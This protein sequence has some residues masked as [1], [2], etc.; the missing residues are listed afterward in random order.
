MIDHEQRRPRTS[1]KPMTS[2]SVVRTKSG[3]LASGVFEQGVRS[4]M[5]FVDDHLLVLKMLLRLE[6]MIEC[7]FLDSH[8][9]TDAPDFLIN[10]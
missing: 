2:S 6:R 8:D 1:R 3:R 4:R 5:N 9:Q 10:S 7:P